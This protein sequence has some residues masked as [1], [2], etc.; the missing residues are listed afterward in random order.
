MLERPIR[1]DLW[2]DDDVAPSPAAQPRLTPSLQGAAPAT[3]VWCFRCERA[4]QRAEAQFEGDSVHCA[5]ADCAGGALDFWQWNAYLAF[6]GSAPAPSRG[7]RYPM[8]QG[9]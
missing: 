1:I 8:A 4:F 2:A 7:V 6:V 3:W 5:Y 9:A